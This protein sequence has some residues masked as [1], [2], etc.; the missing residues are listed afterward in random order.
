MRLMRRVASLRFTPVVRRAP[1]R[2]I[3]AGSDTL[4]HAT[5]MNDDTIAELA[6]KKSWYAPAIDHNQYHIENGDSAYKVPIG[7]KENLSNFISRKPGDG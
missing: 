4:E 7:A 3:R 1:A 6:G 5:D 2:A